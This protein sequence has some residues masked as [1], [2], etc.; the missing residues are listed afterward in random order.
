PQACWQPCVPAGQELLDALAGKGQG[1][2]KSYAGVVEYGRKSRRIEVPDRE[3][4]SVWRQQRVGRS[5]RQLTLNNSDCMTV[6]FTRSR[7]CLWSHA[8]R[9]RILEQTWWLSTFQQGAA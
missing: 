9:K 7:M 2:S 5:G 3:E 6:G 8:Q 1:M 4:S